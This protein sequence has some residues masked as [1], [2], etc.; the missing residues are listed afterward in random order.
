MTEAELTTANAKN[1][2][3]TE[4]LGLTLALAF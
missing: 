1:T 4:T 2:A 3:E